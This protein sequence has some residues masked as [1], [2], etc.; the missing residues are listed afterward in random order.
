MKKKKEKKTQAYNHSC[1]DL[2]I[3]YG[4]EFKVGM[5]FII[6]SNEASLYNIKC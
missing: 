5:L 4:I 6:E 2:F 1:E 3:I